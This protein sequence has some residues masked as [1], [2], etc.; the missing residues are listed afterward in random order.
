MTSTSLC[1][2][3]QMSPYYC[4]NLR[5]IAV[6]H[7]NQPGD[8]SAKGHLAETD[9]RRWQIGISSTR[10]CWH[11]RR[12][13]HN[14]GCFPSTQRKGI[15]SSKASSCFES[16]SA[17]QASARPAA[18]LQKSPPF[19]IAGLCSTR[20]PSTSNPRLPTYSLTRTTGIPLLDCRSDVQV[21]GPLSGLRAS[22]C[23]AVRSTAGRPCPLRKMLPLAVF[24]HLILP[25]AIRCGRCQF[26]TSILVTVEQCF[27]SIPL[28]RE[29]ASSRL[30]CSAQR[31][32]PSSFLHSL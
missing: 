2:T 11:G 12:A 24:P 13:W 10:R 7:D 22:E 8:S 15:T 9:T 26:H 25:H 31:V 32:A 1:D 18:V 20:G 14:S 28:A 19:Q 23:F 30:T 16:V 5:N 17:L 3:A 21:C 27:C 6:D 29:A 4:G